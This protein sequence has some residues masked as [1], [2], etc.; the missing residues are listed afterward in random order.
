MMV[1]VIEFDV[2]HDLMLLSA[3]NGLSIEVAS[4]VYAHEHIHTMTHGGRFPSYR[5]DGEMLE[6]REV[7]IRGGEINTPEEMSQCSGPNMSPSFDEGGLF[8]AMHM[9]MAVSTAYVIPGSSGGPA[10]DANGRL[11]GIVSCTY[12]EFSG[13]VPLHDIIQFLKSH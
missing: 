3:A 5:T 11:I 9:T 2:D 4:K 7:N 13:L 6:E 12:G 1:K 10:M 8:C